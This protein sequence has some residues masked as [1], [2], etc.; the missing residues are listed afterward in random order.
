[1][2]DDH[3]NIQIGDFGLVREMDSTFANTVAGVSTKWLLYSH[4]QTLKY[5]A[6]EIVLKRMYGYGCDIWSLGCIFYEL[7]ML[8]LEKNFYM[9]M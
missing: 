2:G 1:M 4:N 7:A 3:K 8:S 9:E 6:P 5:I